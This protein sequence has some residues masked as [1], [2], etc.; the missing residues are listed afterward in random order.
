MF[1][2]TSRDIAKALRDFLFEHVKV[3]GRGMWAKSEAG[4]WD[5]DNFVITDFSPVTWESLR[6]S[7]DRVRGMN[8]VWPEDPLGEISVIE[9]RNGTR[10]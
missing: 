2:S 5:I 4:K 10:Q 6:Q 9:E 8:L 3:S 1:C 7:V